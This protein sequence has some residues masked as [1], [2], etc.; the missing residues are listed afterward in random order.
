MFH[1]AFLHWKRPLNMVLGA[2]EAMELAMA[3]TEACQLIQPDLDRNTTSWVKTS[4]ASLPTRASHYP[5][6]VR[7]LCCRLERFEPPFGLWNI[8]RWRFC[9]SQWPTGAMLRCLRVWSKCQCMCPSETWANK[10]QRLS[11]HRNGDLPLGCEGVRSN[12]LRSRIR[13]T[14]TSSE[15]SNQSL[16]WFFLDHPCWILAA[17]IWDLLETV[18]QQIRLAYDSISAYD[19]LVIDYPRAVETESV[20]ISVGPVG[21]YDVKRR[22]ETMANFIQQTFWACRWYTIRSI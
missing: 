8:L 11:R 16:C 21:C 1:D 7:K 4:G 5:W 6:V 14:S 12:L 13:W 10:C 15:W 18:Y 3:P 22:P 20:G 17:S 9:Q 2:K 19:M